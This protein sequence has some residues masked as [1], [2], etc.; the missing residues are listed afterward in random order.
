[1]LRGRTPT[2]CALFGYTAV[3]VA[4]FGWRLLPHPGRLLVGASGSEDPQKYVW[5][6]AWWPHAILN[7]TNPFYSHALFAPRGINLAWTTSVPGL[8]VAFSP[9]TLLF[10]P[11]LSYNVA[12]LLLPAISA[13]AA[14]LLLRYVTRSTWAALVGGYLY[15]FS[16]YAVAHQLGGHLCFTAS[17]PAPLIA[18][19]LLR[20]LRDELSSRGLAWRLGVL[21]ALQAYISTEVAATL[22]LAVGLALVLGLAFVPDVRPRL[23]PSLTPIVG[24]Y[25]LAGF[26]AAPLLYYALAQP[27]AHVTRLESRRRKGLQLAHSG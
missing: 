4:Y 26:L 6:F 14:F 15:G 18:L 10:G 7:W 24:G 22:T 2:I 5:W 27:R 21:L 17:F 11:S 8:A 9:L 3:S 25:A 19:V 1:M 23:L 16:S 20:H 13:W 12:A